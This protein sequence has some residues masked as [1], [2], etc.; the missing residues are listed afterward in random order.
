MN[1]P[2]GVDI[3]ALKNLPSSKATFLDFLCR[4]MNDSHILQVLRPSQEMN[5]VLESLSLPVFQV[6]FNTGPPNQRHIAHTWLRAFWVNDFFLDETTNRSLETLCST[7]NHTDKLLH[8]VGERFLVLSRVPLWEVCGDE[9]GDVSA[10][11]DE[12]FCWWMRVKMNMI[13]VEITGDHAAN[14]L[15]ERPV[16]TAMVSV[17]INRK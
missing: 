5:V 10:G 12:R 6:S 16:F 7:F 14:L 2:V 1:V 17:G 8:I 13:H 4:D 9:F 3:V 15:H 11:V